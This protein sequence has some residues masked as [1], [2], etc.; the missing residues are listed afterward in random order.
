MYL[1]TKS[2]QKTEKNPDI[3]HD[4]ER[5]NFVSKIKKTT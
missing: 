2:T 4:L 5:P 3:P 1:P